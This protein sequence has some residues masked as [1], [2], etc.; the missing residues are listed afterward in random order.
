M[1]KLALG[2]VTLALAVAQAASSTTVQLI[3]PMTA[4]GTEL[5][6]GDYK[7]QVDG[8][9]VTFKADSKKAI[10]V[11]ATTTSGTEKYRYTTMESE[12]ST[13]KAIHLGGTNTTIMFTSTSAANSGK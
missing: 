10:T 2:V 8:N 4:A 7:V 11:P 3:N 9:N 1:K 13:L 5:K 12:G 6:A